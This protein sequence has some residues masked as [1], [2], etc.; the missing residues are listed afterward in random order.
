MASGPAP[1]L[2]VNHDA[3]SRKAQPHRRAVFT[4]VQTSYKKWKRQEDALALRKSAK[5][6]GSNSPT[7]PEGGTS[8][9][10]SIHTNS[11]AEDKE[12]L[13][14][15]PPPS[16]QTLLQT[17]NSDPFHAFAIP[18]TA[19]VA[20]V[21]SYTST[22]Y[23][24]GIYR[25]HDVTDRAAASAQ[26]FDEI[27]AFLHDPSTAYPHLARIMAVMPQRSESESAAFKMKGLTSLRKRLMHPDS[28]VDPRTSASVLLFLTAEVYD[29]NLEAAAFHARIL[30]H[31][32]QSGTVSMDFWFL[33]KVMYHDVQRAC[34][35]LSRPAFDLEGWVPQQFSLLCFATAVEM[36]EV[37]HETC[38][39]ASI[40]DP[41]IR[42]IFSEA[43]YCR[44]VSLQVAKAKPANN[45]ASWGFG[46]RTIACVGRIVNYYLDSKE[47]MDKCE[48]FSD[49]DGLTTARA[50]AYT[51]L[52]LLYLIRCEAKMDIFQIGDKD[53][54]FQANPKILGTLLGLLKEDEFNANEK[55]A[56]LKLFAL[57]VGAWAEQGRPHQRE[58]KEWFNVK[59]ANQAARMELRTWIHV[60]EVLL[61]FYYSDSWRPN[62]S[63]WFWRTMCANSEG[64][65]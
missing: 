28:L 24:P 58:E 47:F 54:I 4:H 30:A 35:G 63:T 19:R 55:Y 36:P 26:A 44:N 11:A 62:G 59:F 22:L 2:W 37:V 60:R 25:H 20:Q 64:T 61:G 13:L 39:D 5:V 45:Q 38:V 40:T 56:R 53:T 49:T 9:P 14:I 3:K 51:M 43:R 34:L 65:P 41:R 42:A 18:I 15:T 48:N 27:V 7:T 21:M 12:V 16:P 6:P 8:T 52:A 10:P 32:M 50:E 1:L 29:G 23:L 46:C 17:G 31:L 33:F 57:F